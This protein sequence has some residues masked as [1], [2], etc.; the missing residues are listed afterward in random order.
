[1]KKAMPVGTDKM[2]AVNTESWVGVKFF[3]VNMSK[4]SAV[5]HQMSAT[6]LID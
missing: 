4:L 5:R 3:V 6:I 2:S 1:M